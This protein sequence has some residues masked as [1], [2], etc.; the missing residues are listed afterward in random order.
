M[1]KHVKYL[2]YEVYHDETLSHQGMVPGILA[3]SGIEKQ[4][5][6]GGVWLWHTCP[7]RVLLKLSNDVA[8][9][10]VYSDRNPTTWWN[11][12]QEHNIPIANPHQGTP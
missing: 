7:Q 2:N 8:I 4:F 12:A 5:N 6:L 10:N 3:L 9:A 1:E 11:Y